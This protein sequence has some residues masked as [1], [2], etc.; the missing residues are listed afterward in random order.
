MRHT[1]R[2]SL[3]E[4]RG[5]RHLCLSTSIAGCTY[6]G[7]GALRLLDRLPSTDFQKPNIS[8][9]EPCNESIN[10][11]N[12]LRW[13]VYRQTLYIE[14]DEECSNLEGDCQ[15][16]SFQKEHSQPSAFL[17]PRSIEELPVE[18]SAEELSCAGFNGRVDKVADTC[19]AFWVGGSLAVSHFSYQLFFLYQPNA[20]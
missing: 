11:Q 12:L 9:E 5:E 8:T 4:K 7:V 16:P 14:E 19:Y 18:L 17:E 15:Q 6:C 3:C 1:V 2:C 13:L 20:V 10:V